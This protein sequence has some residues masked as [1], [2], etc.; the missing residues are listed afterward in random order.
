M[1]NT[2][3][4]SQVYILRW[5]KYGLSFSLLWVLLTQGDI[6]SWVIGVVVVPLA[7]WCAICLFPPG[8]EGEMAKRSLRI[9]ALLRFIPFFLEQ[10]LRGGWVS[11]LFALHPR[12]RVHSGFIK[13]T[14]C[15]P[16]GRPRLF[17][18]NTVNL[19]PGTVSAEC[20]GDVM[21]IHALDICADHDQDLRQCEK[22]IAA[23]FGLTDI[24]PETTAAT[25][26]TSTTST[27]PTT[28]T[29]GEEGT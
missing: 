22:Q 1:N 14:T 24:L 13:Y 16:P 20:H 27:T 17:F 26:T 19:L 7:T 21:T 12:K 25:S 10:S 18:I 2:V 6:G 8:D 29:T 15:L 11:A 28:S 9:S 23:L 3:L 5:I 4:S